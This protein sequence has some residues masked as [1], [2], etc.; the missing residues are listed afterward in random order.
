MSTTR[1]CDLCGGRLTD[2][3]TTYDLDG[4]YHFRLVKAERLTWWRTR[5]ETRDLDVCRSCI[6]QLGRAAASTGTDSEGAGIRKDPEAD[7]ALGHPRE[8]V[9][10]PSPDG[11]R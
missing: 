4:R 1:K 5:R 2:E 10:Y 7:S 6:D 9:P 8:S 11:G 3:S